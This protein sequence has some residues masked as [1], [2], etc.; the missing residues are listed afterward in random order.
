MGTVTSGLEKSA[1]DLLEKAG[2]AFDVAKTQHAAADMQHE[3][4]ARQHE[5]ADE[6]HEIAE[7][8]HEIADKQNENAVKQTE[9]AEKLDISADKLDR[10]G[11]SL[12]AE[13]VE[14][15]GAAD[16]LT[17]RSVRPDSEDQF[18]NLA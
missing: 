18:A 6:Q 3:S 10:L 4:A 14:V 2:E 8:Q 12:T 13:A 7:Q 1:L 16:A 5:S 17:G 9:S 15:R 11:R